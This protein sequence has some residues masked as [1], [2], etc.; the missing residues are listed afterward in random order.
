MGTVKKGHPVNREALENAVYDAFPD[1]DM[2]DI[3]RMDTDQLERLIELTR[4]KPEPVK[5]SPPKVRESK[6]P[7]PPVV[8]APRTI[9]EAFALVDGQLMRRT[10][11][12]VEVVQ[13]DNVRFSREVEQLTP[14][15]DRVRFGGRTYRAAVVAHYLKTGELVNRAP[16]AAKPPHYRA[17]VRTPGGLVHLGYFAT[18]E[19][20][21]AAIFAYRLGITQWVVTI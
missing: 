7:A 17:R 1:L 16:R 13:R 12:R 20:R 10:V 4:P 5:P 3:E 2:G 15:G 18:A 11:A 21:E 14:C 6:K 9:G 8:I 19:E